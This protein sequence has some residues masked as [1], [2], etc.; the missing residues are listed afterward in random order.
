MHQDAPAPARILAPADAH[1]PLSRVD[2][3]AARARR[4]LAGVGLAASVSALAALAACGSEPAPT[5][6]VVTAAEMRAFWGLNPGSCWLYRGDTEV[7][8]E[9]S[10]PDSV[11]VAGR[12]VYL[13][14][15]RSL[16]GGL[17]REYRLDADSEPGKLL[18]ARLTEGATAQTRVDALYQ[19]PLPVWSTLGYD[20]AGAIVFNAGDL[21][22]TVTTPRATTEVPNPMS[23]AHRVTVRDRMKTV[24]TS[25]GSASAI[26]IAY[27]HGGKTAIWNLV[28]GYGIA[29]FT[30]D[31][32]EHQVCA[33]RTCDAQGNCTGAA[34][35]RGALACP[36]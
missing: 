13:L 4:C 18:L 33:A 9:V 35:C 5:P 20:K 7:V 31:G 28:P 30:Q 26:N 25:S 24:G 34:D 6:K 10:G 29:L 23:E 3:P 32:V 12:T 2:T 16:S 11:S 27:E 17:P 21:I 8:A 14:Q 15:F 19:A 1:A 22:E 36:R